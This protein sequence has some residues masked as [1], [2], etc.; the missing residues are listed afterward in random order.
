MAK[1]SNTDMDKTPGKRM[2]AK[3]KG[4]AGSTPSK[5]MSP[6]Q[7]VA[8]RTP[9]RYVPGTSR[10]E[11]GMSSVAGMQT[12]QTRSRQGMPQPGQAPHPTD[13]QSLNDVLDMDA[14]IIDQMM[15]EPW[16]YDAIIDEFDAPLAVA[17]AGEAISGRAPQPRQPERPPAKAV[18]YDIQLTN[19]R[20]EEQ[21]LKDVLTTLQAREREL[22]REK[23][24]LKQIEQRQRQSAHAHHLQQQVP[25]HGHAPHPQQIQVP[26]PQQ[27]TSHLGMTANRQ[28]S[29]PPALH[30]MDADLPSSS[31]QAMVFHSDSEADIEIL[32]EFFSTTPWKNASSPTD[33]ASN[34]YHTLPSSPFS[35]CNEV[36]DDKV[37]TEL[38]S[39]EVDYGSSLRLD[40]PL[41]EEEVTEENQQ[42]AAAETP[43]AQGGQKEMTMP[44]PMAYDAPPVYHSMS[45][46]PQPIHSQ[47]Q[48]HF[49]GTPNGCQMEQSQMGH[50]PMQSYQASSSVWDP[51]PALNGLPELPIYYLSD[52]PKE[53]LESP[54]YKVE[55]IGPSCLGGFEPKQEAECCETEPQVWNKA[56]MGG[57]YHMV[58]QPYKCDYSNPNDVGLTN[59]N[60]YYG[61]NNQMMMSQ[62]HY[63][64][65]Y[66]H[67]EDWEQKPEVKYHPANNQLH[68][69][70]YSVPTHSRPA[71]RPSAAVS[72][73]AGSS[74]SRS[75]TPQKPRAKPGRPGIG[76]AVC[77][78][79]GQHFKR[80]WLLKNHIRSHTGEKPFECEACGK[81]FSDKSNLRAHMATHSEVKPFDCLKCGKRFALRS[82][83]TKHQK[84]SCFREECKMYT[85]IDGRKRRG[86][87]GIQFADGQSDQPL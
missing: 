21:A 76:P 31:N 6:G 45:N 78:I 24:V 34:G 60:Q 73:V 17:A 4:M 51:H 70:P 54:N 15:P 50:H 83:L 67:W 61:H 18:Q 56:K 40:V 59:L 7:M 8:K 69:A 3:K 55:Y 41:Y 84:Q 66:D 30:S 75:Q 80:L 68:Y 1:R 58:N 87:N 64:S 12:M 14:P 13:I 20:L 57:Q 33:S 5:L 25:P 16:P 63:Q 44:Q 77:D 48:G 86:A 37:K 47:Q 53:L 39:E 29:P 11:D 85:V 36:L 79:C 35:C 27:P 43:S 9:R 23:E 2:A 32:G 22:V 38:F 72:P 82:Y 71:S 49:D 10:E 46:T 74:Q 28:P 62:A 26:I 65:G 81:A 52:L 19:L 42:A